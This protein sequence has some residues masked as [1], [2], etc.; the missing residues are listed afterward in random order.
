MQNNTYYSARSRW[1]KQQQKNG[2]TRTIIEIHRIFN[3]LAVGNR[4]AQSESSM[5]LG[6]NLVPV[7]YKFFAIYI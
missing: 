5:T 4:K 1:T 6:N 3:F 2:F 7:I